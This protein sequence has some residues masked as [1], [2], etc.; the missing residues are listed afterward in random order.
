MIEESAAMPKEKHANK[1]LVLA[2]DLGGTKVL[3]AVIGPDGKVLGRAK[4]ST[5]EH[6]EPAMLIREIAACARKA[7][8]ASDVSL[9]SISGVGMG[10]PGPVDIETGVVTVAPNLGW[11]NVPAKQLLE[12][13]LALP[14]FLD[15]DVRV[16]MLAEH[17][18]GAAKGM[19]SAIGVFVGT[20]IGGGLI[21]NGQIY[22]G[23]HT[24]AG[25]VGH[26]ITEA[27][28]PWGSCGQ[29]GCLES[30]A[31]RTAIARDL[32][33]AVGK[34]KKTLL[35]KLAGH[36]LTAVRSGDL[37]KAVQSGDRLTRRV[38]R[39]SAKY[40][41]LGIASLVNLLDPDVVILGGGVVEALGSFYVERAAK[42]A[43]RNIISDIVRDVPILQSTLGDDAGILG[44]AEVVRQRT[45]GTA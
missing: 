45:G 44:A 13:E 15:N 39:R 31:S 23:R 11:H 8:Q 43:R 28:G 37:V 35:T 32:Q 25:E 4:A 2:I 12:A 14:V 24:Q 36:D 5:Q 40:V 16:A 22:R 9:D 1:E 29:R 19:Q 10:V 30:L 42:V 27:G 41:G 33:A 21:L 17:R 38:I 34:G 20:G 7:V 3:C 18:F 26:M 6:P